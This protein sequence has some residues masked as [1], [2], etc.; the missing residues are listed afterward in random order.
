M[1][2]ATQLSLFDTPTL[3]AAPGA[4]ETAPAT[5][6]SAPALRPTRVARG[7]GQA[8]PW[9]CPSCGREQKPPMR[10]PTPDLTCTSC[11]MA[12]HQRKMNEAAAREQARSRGAYP[13]PTFPEL[14]A[15]ARRKGFALSWSVGRG[16]ALATGDALP[17]PC[18]QEYGE[19]AALVARLPDEASARDS[20]EAAR[21]RLDHGLV[22]ADDWDAVS[23]IGLYHP[24]LANESH[25]LMEQIGKLY[26]YFWSL[27]QRLER[28]PAPPLDEGTVA[29]LAARG[30]RYHGA[31]AAWEG[32]A[33]FVAGEVVHVLEAGWTA[34]GGVQPLEKTALGVRCLLA[35]DRA[36]YIS[37]WRGSRDPRPY[38]P[39][40]GYKDGW[41]AVKGMKRRGAATPAQLRRL[42]EDMDAAEASQGEARHAA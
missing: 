7:A 32:M 4:P 20:L 18:P 27:E 38:N 2:T 14:I 31:Y 15:E 12:A 30:I 19:L 23:K 29:A 36:F 10:N 21:E 11:A 39:S 40:L 25:E 35:E 8:G 1:N 37:G 3:S 41:A 9:T 34:S 24:A 42:C 13:P 33:G 6:D 5:Q 17:L 26:P 28:Y 22:N 16:Y